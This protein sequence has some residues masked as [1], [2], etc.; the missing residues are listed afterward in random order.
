MQV[1]E[2]FKCNES[3]LQ[4][5]MGEITPLQQAKYL[6][7]QESNEACMQMLEHLW[8]MMPVKTKAGCSD[9]DST[10]DRTTDPENREDASSRQTAK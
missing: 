7:W 3:L 8:K 10:E 1:S 4:S 6:V 9:S 2:T 5:I